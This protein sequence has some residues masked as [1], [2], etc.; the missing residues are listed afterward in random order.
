MTASTEAVPG[1]RKSS[2]SVGNGECVEISTT[3]VT[4]VKVRDSKNPGGP[5][6]TFSRGEWRAFVAGVRNDEFNL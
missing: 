3:G 2:F 4:V 1:W 6:L 5:I